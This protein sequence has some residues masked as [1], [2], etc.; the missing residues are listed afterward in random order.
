MGFLK[1]LI[2]LI[3]IPVFGFVVSKWVLHDINKEIADQKIQYSL[4]E[5]CSPEILSQTSDLNSL[6]NGVKPVLLLQEASIISAIV[7]ILLLLSF[8]VAA[9]VAGRSRSKIT[10]IFPPL[11]FISLLVLAMLVIIQGTILTYGTYLAEVTAIQRV[12]LVLIAAMGLA[13]LAGGL[14]LIKSSFK[15]ASR[16]EHSVMGTVLDQNSQSKIYTFIRDIAEK[17][18][19]RRPDHIV[20]GLE[21]NFYVTSADVKVIGDNKKLSGETLFLSL[22][23]ARIF[24]K[25]E[26]KAVIGHELGH[27]RGHDTYYSLKFSPVYA[28]L[29]HGLSS[30]QSD[31]SSINI[32]TYPAMTLISYM[33]DVFHKNVSTISRE[34]EFEADK[35]ATEVAQPEALATALLKIGLYANAWGNLVNTTVERLSKRKFTRNL[36]RLFSSTVKYDVNKEKIPEVIQDIGKGTITHPTDT[37]PPTAMRIKELGLDIADIN[38]D[39]LLVQDDDN[40]SIDLIYNHMHLE[41]KLT[42]LQ[43]QYYMAHGVKV[44]DD[45][46]THYGA[47][48]IAAFGAHMV[49]VDG[50]VVPEEIDHAESI[51]LKLSESF[52]IIEFREYCHYPEHLPSVKDLLDASKDISAEGKTLIYEYL[53]NIAAADNK[54]SSE[55]QELLDIVQ[56]AFGN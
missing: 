10:K 56:S 15:L 43:Q 7:A 31:N 8:I 24:S 54:T 18:G 52:D 16:Q 11:V 44:P 28:G 32:A 23:L 3:I 37:H 36:S 4:S 35:A 33:I 19:A 6:C 27:F 40:N 49:L 29:T 48:I 38:H 14:S 51:G 2:L 21:P 55:E 34:R 41:E 53:K 26:I 13:A 17:L 20:V 9:K 5:L 12:H 25:E 42:E 30:M 46:E 50:K 45:E 47:A 39:L 1:A 22:P